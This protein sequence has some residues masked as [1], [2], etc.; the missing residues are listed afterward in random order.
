MSVLVCQELD[1][2]YGGKAVVRGFSLSLESGEIVALLGP[3]GAGKT[4]IMLTLAG[5]IPPVRGE[6]Q[7]DGTKVH[8]GDAVGMNRAG[9]VLVPDDRSLF[10]TLTTKENLQLGKKK[11]MSI[12]EVVDLF[13]SLQKAMG[14]Q[15]GTLS[16]GEQQMLAIA[17]ALVQ[18][19]KVLLIDELSM[20]LAPIVVE[21]ILS[22]LRAVSEATSAAIVLVEQHVRLAVQAADR[23]SVVVH[24]REVLNGSSSELLSDPG[25]LDRA[26][27]G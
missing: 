9:L 6:I 2:G 25:R 26:Y 8:G 1:A 12:D 16:G 27:L 18:G 20:G 5:I 15:V 14:R 10:T 22:K 3:N 19:P 21:A 23:A 24:G 13:P 17:R 11:G 7:V 4:T